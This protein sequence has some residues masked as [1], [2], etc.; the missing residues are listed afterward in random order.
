MRHCDSIVCLHMYIFSVMVREYTKHIYI[1][2]KIVGFL[3]FFFTVQLLYMAMASRTWQVVSNITITAAMVE[4]NIA[5]SF[6]FISIVSLLVAVH[7]TYI[8]AAWQQQFAI[9]EL[10]S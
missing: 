8:A 4:L 2:E 9:C 5:F 3:G 1:F 10:V 7:K 6:P